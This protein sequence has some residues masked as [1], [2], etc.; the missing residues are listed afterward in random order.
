VIAWGI[1]VLGLAIALPWLDVSDPQG[2]GFRLRIVAFVP[3]SL[4]AAIAAPLV[5]LPLTRWARRKSDAPANLERLVDGVLAVAALVVV[6]AMPTNR[7]DGKIVAHPLMVE[8]V[9]AVDG[10]IPEGGVAI[11]PER[12]IAFMVRWYAR[13]PVMLRPEQIP[14]ERR[15]RIM[16]LAFIGRGSPLDRA[17]LDARQEPSIEPPIG[18]HSKHP[19]GLVLVSERTWQWLLQRLPPAARD[20]FERWPTI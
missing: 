13:V 15:W 18:L 10:K 17:L 19:N 16:P 8:A 9:S 11:V 6:L 7:T 14:P 20:H 5:C 1:V 4:C 2:L 12:H 3:M